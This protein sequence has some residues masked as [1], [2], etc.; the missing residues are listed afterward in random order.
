MNQQPDDAAALANLGVALTAIGRI[1][2]AVGAFDRALA[3]RPALPEALN[4]RGIAQQRLGRLEEALASYERALAL[5]PDYVA[6]LQ[7]RGNALQALGRLRE[8]LESCKRALDVSPNS[9]SALSNRGNVLRALGRHEEALASYELAL[10][11]KQDYAEAHNNRGNVLRE[12]GR[13]EEA[14]GSYERALAIKLDYVEAHNNRASVLLDLGRPAEALDNCDKILLLWPTD[15]QAH[16]ARGSALRH[17]GRPQEALE[18]YERALVLQPDNANA[19]DNKGIALIE[20]GRLD[21]ARLSFA[22]ALALTPRRVRTYYTAVAS[23]LSSGDET[24]RAAMLELARDMSSLGREEQIELS[25]AL[26]RALGEAKQYDQS[27]SFLM[28]GNA[29]KRAATVYDEARA[30]AALDRT[31]AIV[32]AEFISARKGHGDPS[33]APIF[34]LGMPRS[35]T[36]LIEQIL[37]SHPSVF[38]A[39][40]TGFF[41]AALRRSAALTDRA[42]VVPDDVA[43]IPVSSWRQVGAD[44]LARLNAAAAA[45]Q[46]C[47]DKTVDNFRYAGLIH[48]AL[49]NARI[50]H[51]RRNPVD[52]CLSCYSRNFVGNYPYAYDLAELGRYWNGYDA[53]MEH[54]RAALP[55]DAMLE[56]QY[57]DVVGDLEGQARRI[58]AHCDLEWDA[59][60][61]DFHATERPVRTASATQV[62][63]PIYRSAVERWRIYEPFLRP[64]LAELRRTA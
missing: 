12:L 5:K 3:I 42:F 37:A 44:Y 7:N 1:E 40:E 41:A 33:V 64:L 29:L 20:L 47:T 28:Q 32:G 17:L 43:A 24:L 31:R 10:A 55:P 19:R 34:I 62:R 36:T 60:C 45:G 63:Q 16:D 15:P 56:V 8:A 27:F 26:G 51:A 2:E 25:F 30:L 49:P 11:I 4:G 52:T 58:L 61:L 35:G 48:L 54:W 59:R 18:S 14:L 53:L 50:I 46:I 57:E 21:E 13:H 6:A 39:G 9:P 22:K 38:G 23:G